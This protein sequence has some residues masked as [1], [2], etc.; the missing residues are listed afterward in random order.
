VSASGSARVADHAAR[1]ARDSLLQL[2]GI[3][4]RRAG[5]AGVGARRA[6]HRREPY[7][8]P[9]SGQGSASLKL[10]HS[11]EPYRRRL[12]VAGT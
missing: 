1:T 12:A 8:M 9:G 3:P 10:P 11:V 2:E 4:R 5:G 6:P 7:R